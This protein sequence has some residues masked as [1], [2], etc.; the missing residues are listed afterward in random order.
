MLQSYSTVHYLTCVSEKK[1]ILNPIIRSTLK[2]LK[3]SFYMSVEGREFTPVAS[4][5]YFKICEGY[6]GSHFPKYCFY[7]P[8]NQRA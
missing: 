6:E 1:L 7:Y 4:M 2:N 8:H 5:K 3:K